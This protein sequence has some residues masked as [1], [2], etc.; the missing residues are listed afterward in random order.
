L[1]A[2]AVPPITRAVRDAVAVG[3]QQLHVAR[4]QGGRGGRGQD[5]RATL[6]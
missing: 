2:G 3:A 4:S 1:V 5:R 6:I